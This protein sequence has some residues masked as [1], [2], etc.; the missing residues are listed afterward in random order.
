MNRFQLTVDCSIFLKPSSQVIYQ[1]NIVHTYGKFISVE[2]VE[3][4]GKSTNIHYIANFL[5]RKQIAFIMTREP[6]GTEISEA[7]RH[8]LL[9]PDLPAMHAD[10]ELLLMFAARAEHLHKKILPALQAGKWVLCDRFTDASYAYQGGGR[11]MALQKIAALET[12]LQGDLRPDAT[13]LFDLEADIGLKRTQKRGAADRFEE[14]AIDFF[15]AVRKQYLQMAQDAPQRYHIIQAQY[16]LK[17]VQKQLST[18]LETLLQR[19]SQS[20]SVIQS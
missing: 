20:A 10:T 6:G 5:E 18:T 13:L 8:L 16:D 12:W 17:T 3:G 14:E 2:G 15:N 11:G 4:G 19:L 1:M 9:S 7:I